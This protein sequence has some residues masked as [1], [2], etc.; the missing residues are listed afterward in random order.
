MKELLARIKVVPIPRPCINVEIK[1][2]CVTWE[3][4]T[5]QAERPTNEVFVKDTDFLLK[6]LGGSYV[7][8]TWGLAPPSTDWTFLVE[9]LEKWGPPLP[10]PPPVELLEFTR[11]GYAALLCEMLWNYEGKIHEEIVDALFA[12]AKA[13]NAGTPCVEELPE[14]MFTTVE[15]P[16]FWTILPDLVEGKPGFHL[17]GGRKKIKDRRVWIPHLKHP[18]KRDFQRL[19]FSKDNQIDWVRS[20]ILQNVG[21]YLNAQPLNLQAVVKGSNFHLAGSCTNLLAAY[22][23]NRLLGPDKS[24]TPCACGCGQMLPPG[25]RK[26]ASAECWHRVKE[27]TPKRKIVKWLAQRLRRGII[28]PEFYKGLLSQADE[29]LT[30]G[31]SES[32]VRGVLERMMREV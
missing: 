15:K 13:I 23:L 32:E 12:V 17:Y 1:G 29:M 22:L 14:I 6:V 3:P 19:S 31:R 10:I 9:Y 16:L 2:N 5:E 25:R 27:G 28:S 4:A 7:C 11:M 18:T 20:S 21:D 24:L 26:Y 8:E 30:D